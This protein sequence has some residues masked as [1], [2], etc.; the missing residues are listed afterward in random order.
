M[1]WHD[2][3]RDIRASTNAALDYLTSLSKQFDGDWMLA[4]ASY[5]TGAGNVRRAIRRN[6]KTGKPTDFW[7]L[8]LPQETRAYVPKLIAL[9]LLLQNPE[10]YNVN[11]V[12]V[13][14]TPH[15]AI[16]SSGGQIDLSQ[17]APC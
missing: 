1:G 9:A 14:N 6:I 7:S 12:A 17:V 5:N 2:G 15:F 8:G 3:R 13:D 4:L 11:F 16:A 10:Q